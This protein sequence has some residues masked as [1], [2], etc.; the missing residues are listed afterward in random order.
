[1][2]AGHPDVVVHLH[3]ADSVTEEWTIQ[4]YTLEFHAFHIHQ[5]H[6]RDI[7][8]G[9]DPA[10]APLLD[11]VH[12]PFA[13]RNGARP[14]DAGAD[15]DQA[16]LHPRRD[17]LVRVPLPRARAR[18]QRHDADDPRGG[19]LTAGCRRA[20]TPPRASPAR[21][22]TPASPRARN[23]AGCRARCRRRSAGC[24]RR[25]VAAAVSSLRQISSGCAEQ[26]GFLARLARV[27]ER[28]DAGCVVA[29]RPLADRVQPSLRRHPPLDRCAFSS[30]VSATKNARA[31]PTWDGIEAKA[32]R[33]HRRLVGVERFTVSSIEANWSSSRLCPRAATLRISRRGRR[34]ARTADAASGWSAVRR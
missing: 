21:S 15:P 9:R 28:H 10:T 16:D 8:A 33:Q 12:V 6:F 30:A 2:H 19:G 31:T 17:L 14:R 7:T 22:G 13:A 1:M 27:G 4:N 11:T 29:V 3:G 18:G 32:V 34:P 25:P 26:R 5:V 23:A 20:A 24:T